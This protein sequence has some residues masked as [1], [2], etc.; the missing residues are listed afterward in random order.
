MRE[1][2]RKNYSFQISLLVSIVVAIFS[3]MIGFSYGQYET[4]RKLN[5]AISIKDIYRK[6]VI[7][8]D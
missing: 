5:D 7:V 6:E 2:K 4:Y 3:F 8:N 1:R